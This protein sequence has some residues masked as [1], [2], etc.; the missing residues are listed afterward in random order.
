MVSYNVFKL[1][2]IIIYCNGVI[3]EVLNIDVE[4]CLVLVDGLIEVSK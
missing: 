4:G 3:V 1:G 2:D